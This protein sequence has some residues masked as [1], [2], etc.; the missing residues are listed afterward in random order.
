[1]LQE[2]N[3]Q[4]YNDERWR[5]RCIIVSTKI[6]WPLNCDPHFTISGS[7]FDSRPLFFP[8][9]KKKKPSRIHPWRR[10]LA[11]PKQAWGGRPIRVP[12]APLFLPQQRNSRWNK[13]TLR[14]LKL[15]ITVTIQCTRKLNQSLTT[16]RQIIRSLKT[17]STSD[18][19][20]KCQPS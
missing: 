7:A 10:T 2:S 12:Q 18:H 5:R 4:Y 14:K 15:F 11:I 17:P 1:M 20:F 3:L 16:I 6:G 13:I 19:Y 9:H 8:S